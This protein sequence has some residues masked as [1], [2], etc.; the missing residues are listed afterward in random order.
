MKIKTTMSSSPA[1][2]TSGKTWTEHLIIDPD[3]EGP[4]RA[5]DPELWID[6]EGRLWSF[7]AQTIGH[8]GT[9]AGVWARINDD[10]DNDVPSGQN[11]DDSPTES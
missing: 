3:A 6:P 2:G 5:F 10:P 4:V 1:V 7:W 9:I 11:P 8:D